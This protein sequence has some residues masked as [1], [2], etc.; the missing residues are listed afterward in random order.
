MCIGQLIL[1]RFG[2]QTRAGWLGWLGWLHWLGW[3]G[4][5]WAY[6]LA[7][8]FLPLPLD[9]VLKYIFLELDDRIL[10]FMYLLLVRVYLLNTSIDS[11]SQ[12]C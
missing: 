11:L 9:A 8:S 5:Q 2:V 10:F 1:L 12:C 7:A 4:W 6:A 3:L